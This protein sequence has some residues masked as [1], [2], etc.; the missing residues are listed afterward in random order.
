MAASSW[1]GRE[2]NRTAYPGPV[3]S[4]TDVI[5][6]P[7]W[8]DRRPRTPSHHHTITPSHHHTITPSHHHTITPSLHHSLAPSLHHSITP[9]QPPALASAPVL[10]T[11][12]A[13]FP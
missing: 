12:W 2:V 4:C 8:L 1:N 10:R 7:A 6:T 11:D 9:S 5:H 3:D 13:A